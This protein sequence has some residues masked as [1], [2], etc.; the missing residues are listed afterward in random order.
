LVIGY[1]LLVIGYW[2]LVIGYWLLV[3]GYWLLV[4]GYWL[5]VASA[6]FFEQHPR[7]QE[8]ERMPSST[9]LAVVCGAPWRGLVG[10]TVTADAGASSWQAESAA[11]RL[12]SER[13]AVF[14][15]NRCMV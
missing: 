12:T 11:P 15:R 7:A 8:R 1:W 14:F 4:I 6:F 3:I 10:V 5:L 2:L 13:K 9:W